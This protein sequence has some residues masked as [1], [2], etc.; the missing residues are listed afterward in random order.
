M[1][2]KR[3]LVRVAFPHLLAAAEREV[4]WILKPDDPVPARIVFVVNRRV[5]AN[6]LGQVRERLGDEIVKVARCVA[7]LEKVQ[8]RSQ[9][10]GF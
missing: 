3:M 6:K 1:I 10:L 2:D 5:G 7:A 4:H 8:D 9:V